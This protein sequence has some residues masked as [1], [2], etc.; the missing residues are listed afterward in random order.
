[1]AKKAKT[2]KEL[3]IELKELV[4]VIEHLKKEL[5]ETKLQLNAKVEKIQNETKAYTKNNSF[6]TTKRTNSEKDTKLN[7]KLCT[8]IYTK[9]INWK[10]TLM[11]HIWRM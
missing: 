3:D 2:V 6:T 5:K 7:C 10:D 1:M 11:K 8:K 9:S 4:K